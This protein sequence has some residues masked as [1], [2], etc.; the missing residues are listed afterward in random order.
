MRRSDTLQLHPTTLAG[1]AA[2][3]YVSKVTTFYIILAVYLSAGLLCWGLQRAFVPNARKDGFADKPRKLGEA[4]GP[5]VCFLIYL[6]IA[7]IM[8]P[9][10][11]RNIVAKHQKDRDQ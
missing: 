2:E 10:I 3:L 1:R 7:P 11:V 5:V 8:L 4:F 9:F 6:A